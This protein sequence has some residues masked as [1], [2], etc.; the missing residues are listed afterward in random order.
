VAAT[1]AQVLITV[2]NGIASVEGVAA[3]ARWA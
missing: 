2:D 3:P 1:G